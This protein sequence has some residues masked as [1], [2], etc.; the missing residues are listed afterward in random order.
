MQT[1]RRKNQRRAQ[2]AAACALAILS[3]A[4]LGGCAQH[5]KEEKKMEN[6]ER[7]GIIG[8]MDTEVDALKTAA[9]V[10][11]TTAV[12]DMIFCEGTLGG[13][14]VVIVKCGMGKVNAAICAHT[15]IWQFGCTVVINTGVAGSLDPRIDIGDIVVSTDAVQHDFDVSPIGFAR[16]E[17]PYTGLAAFPADEALRAAAVRAVR[18]SAPEIRAFEGRVC[19][20]DQFISEIGQKDTIVSRFGGL[21]C[22]MEGAAIAQACY[23]NH[24]PFVVIRAISD[25]PDGSGAVDFETFQAA[26]ADRCAKI[27]RFLVENWNA[28]GSAR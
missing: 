5:H 23:L 11:Q 10:T 21:C 25:K 18:E 8:A 2:I 19:S 24:T 1:E 26:A 22:E 17:I 4:L 15:L 7:I 3:C 16:G 6:E 20:G 13:Q 27:V 9:G 14:K 12:A 28:A